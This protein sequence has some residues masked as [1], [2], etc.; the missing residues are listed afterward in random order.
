MLFEIFFLS[1]AAFIVVTASSIFLK[2]T[3]TRV[4]QLGSKCA[5][6]VTCIKVGYNSF[7]VLPAKD[8][9]RVVSVKSNANF[10]VWSQVIAIRH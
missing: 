5:M 1:V 6:Q 8:M 4:A 3:R 10:F 2:K 7:K 9:Y